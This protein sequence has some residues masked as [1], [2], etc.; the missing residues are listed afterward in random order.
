[1]SGSLVASQSPNY[2]ALFA[3]LE[4]LDLDDEPDIHLLVSI[5]STARKILLVGELFGIEEVKGLSVYGGYKYYGHAQ[6]HG[7][8]RLEIHTKKHTVALSP[9]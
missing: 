5:E 6:E 4:C 3:L 1:M 2:S 9:R 8:D 7:W